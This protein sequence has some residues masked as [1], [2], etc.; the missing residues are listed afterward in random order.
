M[1]A[2]I[3]DVAPG[4][5]KT[6]VCEEQAISTLFRNNNNSKDKQTPDKKYDKICWNTNLSKQY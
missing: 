6:L 4:L 5:W 1:F 3:D 2:V